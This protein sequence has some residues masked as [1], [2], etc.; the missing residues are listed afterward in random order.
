[1]VNQKKNMM[2]KHS[3]SRPSWSGYRGRVE[4]QEKKKS[5]RE[6]SNFLGMTG[7]LAQS[8]KEMHV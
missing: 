8:K 7:G 1:V 5:K 6:N 2:E 4:A 3:R